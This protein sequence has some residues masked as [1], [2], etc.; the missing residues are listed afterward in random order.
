MRVRA[1]AD[2]IFEAAFVLT[3]QATK[4]CSWVSRV[5]L[6]APIPLGAATAAIAGSMPW[7]TAAPTAGRR[8]SVTQTA[9]RSGPAKPA[10]TGSTLT[11]CN[12]LKQD[13]TY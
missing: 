3:L 1:L 12:Q 2:D 13:R 4:T 10:P 6:F 9:N 5:A 11:R 8:R 7:G